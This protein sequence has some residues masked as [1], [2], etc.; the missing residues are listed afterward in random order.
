M[1]NGDIEDK[2]NI[3]Q[4]GNAWNSGI[5]FN[6]NTNTY[7]L[8]KS[9]L[10]EADRIDGDLEDIYD[11][12]HIN[13]ATGDDL[14]KIGDLVN[15]DR[16]TGEGDD[17][18]RARIKGRFRAATIGTTFDEFTEFAA[19]V[20]NTESENIELIS[21]YDTEPAVIQLATQ[22]SVYQSVNLSSS[23]LADLL[24]DGVPAG[25]DVRVLERGTFRLKA[26][27]EVDDADKGLTSDSIS[28]GG[29]LAADLL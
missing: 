29:T 13:T 3:R 26:D 1:A 20:L 8:V 28:T 4:A 5:A 15:V 18:Y 10:S 24:N 23:E 16:Q 12:H 14:D 27:G 9:L 2:R 25:H 7:K 11:Q 21:D 22:A 6:T 19:S 17:R